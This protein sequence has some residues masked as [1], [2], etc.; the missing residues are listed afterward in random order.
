M[1]NQKSTPAF[2]TLDL[3]ESEAVLGRH[4][5]GRLAYTF[6]DRVDIEPIH[7]VF[8]GGRIFGR[9]QFGKKME[10]LSH[11]PWVA[12]EVDEVEGLFDWRSVVVHGRIAFPDPNGPPS[13]QA[14]HARGVEVFQRLVA[15][16]FTEA[17]PS[18]S[19]AFVFVLHISDIA[20][21]AASTSPGS[22]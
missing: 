8:D 19:R 6:H 3:A 18:P 21:R 5:V 4:H 10:V 7:Y 15:G 14:Q 17:D 20:G 11:A 12:F 22:H 16:A 1:S 2:R 9:M 13:E